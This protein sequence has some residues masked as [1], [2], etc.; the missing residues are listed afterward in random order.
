MTPKPSFQPLDVAFAVGGCAACALVFGVVLASLSTPKDFE[1]RVA[2]LQGQADRG[3]SLLKPPRERSSYGVDALCTRDPNQQAQMLHELVTAQAT[4]ASLVLDALETRMEPADASERL[5]PVRLRFSVT[6]SYDG[7]VGLL[8]LLSRERPQLFV[9]SLD[10]T[11][12][13]SNVTLSVSGRVFC[14]V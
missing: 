11:P 6:G 2:A 4:Q 12:K 8:A 9:D 5:I 10:L 13:V 3:A 7:A 14:G 1:A